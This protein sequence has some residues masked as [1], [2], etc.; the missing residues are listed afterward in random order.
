MRLR[1]A[2]LVV[3][4]I[5]SSV[6]VLAP[7]PAASAALAA[8]TGL[9]LVSNATYTVD[10]EHGAVHVSVALNAV[11]HLKD[12]KTR[13]YYFDRA[14]LAVPPNTT[15]FKIAARTGGPAVKVAAKKKD[16]TLLRIDFGKRLPAGSSRGMTLT[17]DIRDPGG[18]PT[19]T[20]RIGSSLVAFGAWAYASDGTGG[21]TVTVIF[22]PGYTIDAKSDE[23]AKP[24]TDAAGRTVYKTAALARPLAFFAYFVADKASA[25]SET[26]RTVDV[27]GRSLDIT[28]RAW[29]DDPSWAERT[30]DL[31]EQ[32]VPLM[33]EAIGLPWVADRPFIVTEAVTQSGSEYA[34]RYDPT[35]STVEVAYYASPLVTLHETAHAWFD[36]GLL[37]D[38]WAN[39]GFASWYALDA[40]AK[41]DLKVAPTKISPEMAASRIPLNAWGPPGGDEASDAYGYAASE[42]LARLVAE[43]AGASGLSSVW[44]AA[45]AG[46]AAYQPP[47][48]NEMNASMGGS[49]AASDAAPTESGAPPPDWR[50]LLDL[51]EDRTGKTYDDLWRAW[52]VRDD[53][54]TLLDARAS[55]RGQYDAVVSKAGEWR[56]PP[57]VREAMRA[58]QFE[59]ATE[60]LSAADRALDDRDEVLARA[61]AARLTAP[62]ALEAAFEG[63]QGFVAASVEADAELATIRAY[64][65]AAAIREP[66]PGIV[67]QVGLWG[68]TPNAELA[69][70]KSAFETGDLRASVEASAAAY[71][72]WDSARER[73]RNRVMTMLAAAI[74]ALVAVAFIV[75]GARGVAR[76]RSGR[77]RGSAE[78]RGP[79]TTASD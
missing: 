2:A 21:S 73:G 68:E 24:L 59:Q 33:A 3:A 66:D 46:I 10:P 22:P 50:G 35:D 49:A 25:F 42:Q 67:E 70:A 45:N 9:T 74:A 8:A 6:G 55:A 38:R 20:T 56:L 64:A 23:L 41:L 72:A 48:A 28:L 52:V 1:R 37:A 5:A 39:E 31:V 79:A 13:L 34:G 61:S 18:A 62:R 32:A 57:I 30:G 36:G 14:F 65:E 4:L 54:A 26:T 63:N 43:R 40:G 27:A 19:R 58:W 78:T 44:H 7:S 12:T 16:H 53:E 29:P 76:R 51:L 60:L 15:G 17:F 47:G 69:T 75:N 71:G 11:N 77:R